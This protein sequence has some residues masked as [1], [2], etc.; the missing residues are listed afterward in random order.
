MTGTVTIELIRGIHG[1]T[2]L[3]VN[4]YRVAGEKPWGGGTTVNTWT[5]P[6]EEF[7]A[8][9]ENAGVLKDIHC[10]CCGKPCDA[11]EDG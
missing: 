1:H 6:R 2:G 8:A 5:M 9:L 10:K 4:D 11:E 3:Y 7:L